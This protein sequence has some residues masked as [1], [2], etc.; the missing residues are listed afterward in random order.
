MKTRIKELRQEKKYTQ[1]LLALKAETNQTLLSRIE[2]GL[3]VPDADLI[4]RLSTAFHVSAD[5]ILCL[6]DQ[7][8]PGGQHSSTA[9]TEKNT[10]NAA[11]QKVHLSLFQRLNPTQ[12]AH[13]NNFL[14]SM[15]GGI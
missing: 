7:R 10:E 8:N 15:T 1:E 4:V 6:S 12:R 13:L 2:C 5:Y 11:W 14:E 3:A 9:A